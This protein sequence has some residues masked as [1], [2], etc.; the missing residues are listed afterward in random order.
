M[1]RSLFCCL[2][3]FLCAALADIVV[4]PFNYNQAEISVWLSAAAFCRRDEYKTRTFL[5]PTAGFN[6]TG[7]IGDKKSDAQGYVG[8]LP[9]DKSIY[10]VFR[11]SSSIR[12]WIVD[13]DA[14][15]V[16]AIIDICFV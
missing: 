10:V 15:K 8:Y 4:T 11:G 6:L 5:G 16:F 12:N 3:A 13:L 7:I 1:Q 9:S 14:F 2:T